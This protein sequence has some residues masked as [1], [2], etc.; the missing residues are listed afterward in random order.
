[1][2]QLQPQQQQQPQMV[3]V[4]FQHFVEL[5]VWGSTKFSWKYFVMITCLECR[6]SL[7]LWI[8]Q[9]SSSAWRIDSP[10]P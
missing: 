9:N 10:L 3:C 2:P 8:Q 6:R 5:L 7:P 1:L 4:I